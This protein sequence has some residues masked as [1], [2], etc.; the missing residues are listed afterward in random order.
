L[1]PASLQKSA[2]YLHLFKDVKYGII[3]RQ[4]LNLFYYRGFMKTLI[5][6]MDGTIINSAKAMTKSINYVRRNYGLSE[7]SVELVTD[8]INNVADINLP[9]VF[10]ETEE[11]LDEHRA[12][13]RESY[14][15]VCQEETELFDGIFELLEELSGD[16]KIAIATNANH[17]YAELI[18][19]RHNI[20]SFVDFIIGANMVKNGKPDPEMLYAV[21][22]RFGSKKEAAVMIGDTYKDQGAA[23]NAGMEFIFVDWGFGEKIPSKRIAKNALELRDEILGIFGIGAV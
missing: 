3:Y 18:A 16:F 17:T 11:Y 21:L 23:L 1:Q 2:S 8:S 7:V 6:D 15:K 13:F 22:N 12:L 4:E 19:K 10:Y 9:K 14:T 20:D 5:F